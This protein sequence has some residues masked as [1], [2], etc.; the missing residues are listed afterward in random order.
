[1]DWTKIT[2][3]VDEVSTAR[4]ALASSS[5]AA[6]AAGSL[7][8][9]M[10][11]Y[12][13]R[14]FGAYASG[15]A[16]ASVAA[17]TA[18]SFRRM[19]ARLAQRIEHMQKFGYDLPSRWATAE[20]AS[21][22]L[23]RGARLARKV[24]DGEYLTQAEL[25]ALRSDPD[26][27]AG[28]LRGLNDDSLRG[29]MREKLDKNLRD[30]ISAALAGGYGT[31]SPHHVEELRRLSRVLNDTLSTYPSSTGA[32]F[33]RSEP[34][35]GHPVLGG[36]F[37]T[38]LLHSDPD[39]TVDTLRRLFGPHH[40]AGGPDEAQSAIDPRIM[41]A[42]AE[43]AALLEAIFSSPWPRTAARAMTEEQNRALVDDRESMFRLLLGGVVAPS[44]TKLDA[45][46]T[47]LRTHWETTGRPVSPVAAEVIA[48]SMTDYFRELSVG[49]GLVDYA[50]SYGDRQ[51]LGKLQ[52]VGVSPW[53][54]GDLILAL[55]VLQR[56][57][58][59]TRNALNSALMVASADGL[60][61]HTDAGAGSAAALQAVRQMLKARW[62][63]RKAGSEERDASER[64]STV[65]TVSDIAGLVPVGGT[66]ASA[67]SFLVSGYASN[68][69]DRH[70][71][72]ATNL[73]GEA[74]RLAVGD[75]QRFITQLAEHH[76][77][78]EED[79]Q[80]LQGLADYIFLEGA[81]DKPLMHTSRVGS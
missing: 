38:S 52:S 69:A 22:A 77:A 4:R 9:A 42:I 56:S 43:H 35:D 15:V 10:G 75:A 31:S 48:G 59:G 51:G 61:Q 44:A 76:Y 78:N 25:E 71:I 14:A 57:G 29:S 40:S 8:I 33:M 7:S 41:D 53:S 24:N 74:L 19:S 11:D 49:S 39:V 80:N 27:A 73:E 36:L 18:G 30:V 37:A 17:S 23:E 62:T 72:A 26:G 20:G 79:R 45:L 65:Q 47:A 3:N 2:F 60:S 68:A 70:D 13:P 34:F 55:D 21:R 67:A 50:V 58:L 64:W 63:E 12:T 28:Y 5:E 6:Q 54:P 46:T 32:L 81:L 1:M 66:A 16:A